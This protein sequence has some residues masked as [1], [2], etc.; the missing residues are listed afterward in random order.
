MSK[1][2]KT[3][4]KE[5]VDKLINEHLD[6]DK[7]TDECLMPNCHNK[8]RWLAKGGFSKFCSEQCSYNFR[9]FVKKLKCDYA[10]HAEYENAKSTLQPKCQNPMCDNDAKYLGNGAF[11]SYCCEKCSVTIRTIERRYAELHTQL[12]NRTLSTYNYRYDRFIKPPKCQNPKCNN[13]VTWARGNPGHWHKYCSYSCNA[14]C[15]LPHDGRTMTAETAKKISE[16]KKQY[17][18]THPQTNMHK[19]WYAGWF[20]NAK[21]CLNATSVRYDSSYEFDF[22]DMVERLQIYYERSPIA[23]WYTGPDGI[24]HTYRP[25]FVV[26]WQNHKILIEIKAEGRV[27]DLWTQVKAKA[28][29]AQLDKY[30]LHAYVI[31]CRKEI[32]WPTKHI[33]DSKFIHI[34]NKLIDNPD[35]ITDMHLFDYDKL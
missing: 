13:T 24:K 11:A 19:K 9:G 29:I 17:Y 23:F 5:I 34:L 7:P 21:F 31:I 3:L 27:K 22:I 10:K 25:D 15:V 33:Y 26:Y 16:S 20:Q 2:W 14:I 12:L 4:S 30:E 32:S 18:A 35:A 1:E 28:A 8:R 6:K